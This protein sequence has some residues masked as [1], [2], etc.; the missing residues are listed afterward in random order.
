MKGNDGAGDSDCLSTWKSIP[1]CY[2]AKSAQCTD[3]QASKKMKSHDWSHEACHKVVEEA[4]EAE[5]A[6]AHNGNNRKFDVQ[7]MHCRRNMSENLIIN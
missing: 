7:K 1:W 2:V 4:L 3:K 5:A 6:M